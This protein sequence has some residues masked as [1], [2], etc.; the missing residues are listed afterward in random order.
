MN[1][2]EIRQRKGFI[3]TFETDSNN[4]TIKHDR[5]FFISLYSEYS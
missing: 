3:H 5:L 4:K 2:W 1:L